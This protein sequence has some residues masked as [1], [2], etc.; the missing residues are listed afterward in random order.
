MTLEVTMALKFLGKDPNSLNNGS[1]TVY[2]DEERDT[3]V[4]Q[5][6]KVDD[7]RTKELDVPAHETVIEF[8][9]RMMQFFPEVTGG[10]G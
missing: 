1:P 7:E 6:W 2:L 4:L 9:R 3:Y 5:G 8:P 10:N